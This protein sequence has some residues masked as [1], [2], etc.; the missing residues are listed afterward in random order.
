ME[1]GRRPRRAKRLSLHSEVWSDGVRER[2]IEGV[3]GGK[4]KHGKD[5]EKKREN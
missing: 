3:R 4:G 2:E 5:R 1:V